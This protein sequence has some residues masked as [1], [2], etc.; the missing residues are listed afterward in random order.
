MTQ[1]EERE[2]DGDVALQ[3]QAHRQQD[4][5]VESDVGRGEEEC[6]QVGE[7]PGGG[8]LGP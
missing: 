6:D 2:A 5:P 1:F 7:G 3:R 4:R 8:H